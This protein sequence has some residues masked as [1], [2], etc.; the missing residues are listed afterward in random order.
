[1]CPAIVSLMVTGDAPVSYWP[2]SPL[3]LITVPEIFAKINSIHPLVSNA[4]K[5]VPTPLFLSDYTGQH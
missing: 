4:A 3:S 2:F 5:S 1:M